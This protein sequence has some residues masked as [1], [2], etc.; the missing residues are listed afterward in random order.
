MTTN[1]VWSLVF[2]LLT[3]QQDSMK[4]IKQQ[5]TIIP[6]LSLQYIYL[7]DC[8]LFCNQLLI[9]VDKWQTVADQ[10][11]SFSRVFITILD[12]RV[13]LGTRLYMYYHD[14]HGTMMNQQLSGTICQDFSQTFGALFSSAHHRRDQ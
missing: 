11:Q 3:T 7:N 12:D 4:K 2:R 5:L 10:F 13:L 6:L 9:V 14:Y 1:H 8:L